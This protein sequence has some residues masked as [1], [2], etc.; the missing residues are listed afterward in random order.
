MGLSVDLSG[1]LAIRND[2]AQ[3]PRAATQ[4]MRRARATL[5]RR[6]PVAARRDIQT[7]Y[8]LKAARVMAGLAVRN[9]GDAVVL[10][11]KKRGVGLIEFAGRWGGRKT[12]GASAQVHVGAGR[13]M[14]PGTFIAVGKNLNRHI[15]ARAPLGGGRAG[16]LPLMTQYG[17]SI[18]QMLR[19]PG[20]ADRLADFAQSILAAEVDRLGKI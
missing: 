9:D 1:L 16:R 13:T 18:A 14:R 3:A 17:P 4:V 20:R 12:A 7:E 6:L 10:T 5:V 11:G 8:A 19:R 2:L 15:F